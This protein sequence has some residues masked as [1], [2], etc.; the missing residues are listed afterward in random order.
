MVALH[1]APVGTPSNKPSKVANPN[2]AP[3]R[4]DGALILEFEEW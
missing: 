1:K 2:R 4:K 3:S